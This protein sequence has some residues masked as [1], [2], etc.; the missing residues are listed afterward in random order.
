MLKKK[1]LVRMILFTVLAGSIAIAADTYYFNCHGIGDDCTEWV[2]C[3]GL[4]AI[5]VSECSYSC[6]NDYGMQVG[7][8]DCTDPGAKGGNG[9]FGHKITIYLPN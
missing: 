8:A 4:Y 1:Y 9:K 3:S 2:Y 5:P 6:Y 7:W